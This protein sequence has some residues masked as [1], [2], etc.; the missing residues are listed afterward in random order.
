[1]ADGKGREREEEKEKSSKG[2]QLHS[3][4]LKD[5]RAGDRM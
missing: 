2:R 3:I 4:A 1:M 5:L